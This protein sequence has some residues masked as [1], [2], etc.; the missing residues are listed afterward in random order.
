MYDAFGSAET[1]GRGASGGKLYKD[2]DIDFM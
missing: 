1:S 2:D